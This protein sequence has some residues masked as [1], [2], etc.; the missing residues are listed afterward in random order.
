LSLG[1]LTGFANVGNEGTEDETVAVV[2]KVIEYIN[3][4]GNE[5][6]FEQIGSTLT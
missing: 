6:A 1:F 3:T 2:K 5:E 4:N